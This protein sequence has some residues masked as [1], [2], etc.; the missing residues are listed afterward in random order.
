MSRVSSE[1]VDART[2]QWLTSGHIRYS[3]MQVLCSGCGGL[4]C[5][6][7]EPEPEPSVSRL[8]LLKRWL[9]R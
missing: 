3:G 5:D 7:C 8:E 6:L 4:G 9:R 2:A 1:P